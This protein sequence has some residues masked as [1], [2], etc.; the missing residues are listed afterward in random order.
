MDFNHKIFFKN[1]ILIIRLS[2]IYSHN[3]NKINRNL[4]LEFQQEFQN[5]IMLRNPKMYHLKRINYYNNKIHLTE[6][7]KTTIC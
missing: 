4:N 7:F 2:V 5:Q 1:N 3:K 6:V